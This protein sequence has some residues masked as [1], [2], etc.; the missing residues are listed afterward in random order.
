MAD[1]SEKSEA[2]LIDFGLSKRYAGQETGSKMTTVV[3]TPYY[4]APEVLSGKYGRECDVWS[5]GVILYVF[6]CGYPPFE[7]DSN[8][9]IFK[10]IMHAELKF[11]P[12][13]WAGVSQE[14]KELLKMMLERNV[15]KRITAVDAL[16]HAFF[17]KKHNEQFDKGK[18][19]KRMREYR[20][21]L[22]LQ[23]E[24]LKLI[25]QTLY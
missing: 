9:L 13:E 22:Q 3:G 6:L 1:S 15:E 16:S 17:K 12:K 5:L 10:N 23:Q 8:T 11:D 14:A 7:G 19:L 18:I 21:P 25:A 20:A 2:K 4:V 24:T